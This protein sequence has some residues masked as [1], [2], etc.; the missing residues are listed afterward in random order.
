MTYKLYY[1]E[2]EETNNLWGRMYDDCALP[3]MTSYLF[4][5]TY[6]LEVR[7]ICVFF[8]LNTPFSSAIHVQ[9]TFRPIQILTFHEI[10]S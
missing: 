2:A 9:W 4:L 3:L 1:C 10:I 7:T 6:N 8:F 5:S